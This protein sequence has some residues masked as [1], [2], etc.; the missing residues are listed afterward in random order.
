MEEL[1][2]DLSDVQFEDLL[3][4]HHETK[5]DWEISSATAIDIHRV[6]AIRKE[7]PSPPP[8]QPVQN[9]PRRSWFSW[10]VCIFHFHNGFVSIR[11]LWW[12]YPN[13]YIQQISPFVQITHTVL[14]FS[15][16]NR[17]VRG[18]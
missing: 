1:L 2:R 13:V 14:F 12:P 9:I 15:S 11:W 3:R 8:E 4:Y 7:L 6:R 10:A 17:L 5:S 16:L 18:D